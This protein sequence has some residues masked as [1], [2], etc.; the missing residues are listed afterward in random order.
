MDERIKKNT[1]NKNDEYQK[2]KSWYDWNKNF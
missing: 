2:Q 1:R